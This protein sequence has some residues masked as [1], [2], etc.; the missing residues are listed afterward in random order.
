MNFKFEF[1][2]LKFENF[3]FK[4][5]VGILMIVNSGFAIKIVK[6]KFF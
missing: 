6:F 1:K 2:I 5:T 4:M 3:E